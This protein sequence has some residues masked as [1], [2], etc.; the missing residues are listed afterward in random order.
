MSSPAKTTAQ[1]KIPLWVQML[2]GGLAGSIAEIATIPLDTAKVRLQI[3]GSQIKPGEVAKYRGLIHCV[4]RVAQEEGVSFLYRGLVAGLQRQ[5]VFASLRIG[6]YDSVRDYYCGKDFKGDP[7]I[8]KKILAGLTTGAFAISIANPTDVVKVRLQAE[9]RLPPDVPRKYNSV[10]DAYSKIIKQEGVAGLWRGWGPNVLRN[11][12]I[13]A[14]ELA[15]YDEIKYQIISRGFLNDGIPCHFVSSAFAGFL[16]VIFGSPFDVV[17]TRMMNSQKGIGEGYK[18]PLD[19]VIKTLKNEG[20]LAFYGGFI[21]NC[22]R[23]VTWN[24]VM[25][26]SLQQLRRIYSEVFLQPKLLV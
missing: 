16:A 7:P 9:G 24:I 23:L 26:M 13:N 1:P 17:K 11:S 2:T 6:L 15:S 12:V 25:F 4:A 8:T 21:A 22:S 18:N 20:P 3:Q 5:M 10:T 14:V 19:C